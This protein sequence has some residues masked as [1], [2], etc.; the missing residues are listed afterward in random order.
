MNAVSHA[1]IMR[2]AFQAL[3]ETIRS[4]INVPEE[5]IERAGNYPDLFDDPSVPPEKKRETDPQW[6]KYIVYP[7][8][9]RLEVSILS[10]FPVPNSSR[11]FRFMSIF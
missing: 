10:P 1:G 6:E 7:E 2:G 11:G 8:G 5:M 3:P 9:L 4:R